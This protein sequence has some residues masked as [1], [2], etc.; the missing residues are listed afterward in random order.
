M[1]SLMVAGSKPI[2]VLNFF[3]FHSVLF[4]FFDLSIYIAA[5]YCSKGEEAG[6]CMQEAKQQCSS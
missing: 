4:V 2:K 3:I 6:R 1:Y 5:S